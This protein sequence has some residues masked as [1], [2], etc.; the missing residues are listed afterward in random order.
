MRY[1]V[2]LL[3]VVLLVGCS[4]KASDK[5]ET[6]GEKKA[7][8]DKPV[9]LDDPRIPIKEVFP[10]Y[11]KNPIT[12]D[13]KYKGKTI[14]VSATVD[15]ITPTTL[16]FFAQSG[17]YELSLENYRKLTP[18]EKKRFNE[19]YEPSLICETD[20]E[21]KASFAGAEKGK[22][23]TLIGRCVGVR[24]GTDSVEGWSLVLEKCRGVPPKK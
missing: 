1:H 4:S 19:G 13:A 5:P 22:K 23:F 10:E 16:G 12:A 20:P 17:F 8:A 15:R 18:K 7:S 24:T 3:L 6:S 2:C 14:T 21:Q 11:T 9:S